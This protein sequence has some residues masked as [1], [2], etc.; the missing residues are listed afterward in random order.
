MLRWNSGRGS[1]AS[2]DGGADCRGQDE[3]LNQIEEEDLHK[4]LHS[5]PWLKGASGIPINVDGFAYEP[6]QKLLA[7]S[8][9]DGRVKVIGRI[10]CE[11]TLYSAAVKPFGTRQ[12]EFVVNRGALV[13]I[14]EA[15]FLEAW[16]IGGAVTEA[17][18]SCVHSMAQIKPE[19]DE[20]LCMA[21]MPREP[22]LLLGCKSGIMRAAAFV[23]AAGM[24]SC[25][26]HTASSLQLIPFRVTPDQM[27]AAGA[28]VLLA[29]HSFAG[30]HLVLAMHE[31]SGLV[32]WDM[33]SQKLRASLNAHA[34]NPLC[35]ELKDAGRV[36]ACCWLSSAAGG[37]GG[38]GTS[39]GGRDFA[40]GHEG[41]DVL[42]WSLPKLED[43]VA[44][45]KAGSRTLPPP[46]VVAT[47]RLASKGDIAEPVRG[48]N[49]VGQ[50]EGRDALL[51]LGGQSEGQPDGLM[52]LQLSGMAR[53]AVAAEQGAASE[54]ESDDDQFDPEAVTRVKMP[55]FGT[56]LGY[57]TVPR[58]GNVSGTEEPAAIVQLL[59]GGRLVVHS[60]DGSKP[61]VFTMPFQSLQGVSTTG[62]C[63]VP[64]THAPFRQIT[65]LTLSAMREVA[66]RCGAM[67]AALDLGVVAWSTGDERSETSQALSGGIP[68]QPNPDLSFGTVY[69][70]GHKDGHVRTWDVFGEQPQLLFSTPHLPLPVPPLDSPRQSPKPHNTST[71]V[72]ALDLAWQHGL[73]LTGH[74][75][76]EVRLYNFSQQPR[77]VHVALLDSVAPASVA[78]SPC[79]RLFPPNEPL[80]SNPYPPVEPSTT[81]RGAQGTN[82]PVMAH[83][84][85]PSPSHAQTRHAAQ[86]T[87]AVV[88]EGQ[89]GPGW[90][91]RLLC[92]LHQAEISCLTY[93]AATRV[94]VVGD[95]T[96]VV[97]V[98]DV[99]RALVLWSLPHL[100]LPV[101][102]ARLAHVRLPSQRERSMGLSAIEGSLPEGVAVPA[103]TIVS[104]D[105]CALVVSLESGHP[106]GKHGELR[107][108]SAAQV[109]LVELLDADFSPVWMR[110]VL[111]ANETIAL[112]EEA[113]ACRAAKRAERRHERHERHAGKAVQHKDRE[114]SSSGW[115][116]DDSGEEDGAPTQGLGHAAEAAESSGGGASGTDEDSDDVDDC[117]AAAIEKMEEA[118]RRGR[119][120]RVLTFGVGGDRRKTTTE[121]SLEDLAKKAAPKTDSAGEDDEDKEM[122]DAVQ[123]TEQPVAEHMLQVTDSYIRIYSVRHVILGSSCTSAS[124]EL[125][126]PVIFASLF[127]LDDAP[128]LLTVSQQDGCEEAEF[129]VYAV[130]SLAL[131]AQLP[132]RVALRGSTWKPPQDSALKIQR[133]L[134]ASRLGRTLLIGEDNELLQLS[135]M[136]DDIDPLVL[137]VQ[138]H[139][140]DLA[141]AAHAAA[142]AFE[143]AE[144]MMRCSKGSRKRR[145]QQELRHQ[146]EIAHAEHVKYLQDMQEVQRQREQQ[147]QRE[148]ADQAGV[149]RA[150]TSGRASQEA[151][152]QPRLGRASQQQQEE[153]EEGLQ[154]QGSEEI[155]AQLPT[156]SSAAVDSADAEQQ[157]QQEEEGGAAE[158]PTKSKTPRGFPGLLNK[159][160][161][162]ISK[163]FTTTTRT[164]VAIPTSVANVFQDSDVK[165]EVILPAASFTQVDPEPFELYDSQYPDLKSL[166][167]LPM[168]KDPRRGKGNR[169]DDGIKPVRPKPLVPSNAGSCVLDSQLP[170]GATSPLQAQSSLQ[171]AEQD[172]LRSSLDSRRGQRQGAGV[173]VS[174]SLSGGTP[175][176]KDA[177]SLR[178][179][180]GEVE[181]HATDKRAGRVRKS[182]SGLRASMPTF[183]FSSNI[184]SMG[185]R[186]SED[187]ERTSRAKGVS[188]DGHRG[189]TECNSPPGSR[190]NV[191]GSD[192]HTSKD[193]ERESASGGSGL[194]LLF[195]LSSRRREANSSSQQQGGGSCS[196]DRGEVAEGGAVGQDRR[197]DDKDSDKPL[198]KRLA[199]KLGLGVSTSPASDNGGAPS[200]T[201][202]GSDALSHASRRST[203]EPASTSVKDGGVLLA[204]RS[205]SP[206]RYEDVIGDRVSPADHPHYYHPQPS[207]RGRRQS[208]DAAPSLPSRQ[209]QLHAEEE[210]EAEE[211]RSRGSCAGV[212]GRDN[213]DVAIRRTASDVKRKYGRR[214]SSD[215][216]TGATKKS[217]TVGGVAS[218][219]RSKLAE[220]GEKLSAIKKLTLEM[221]G[222]AAGFAEMARQVA[223][224]EKG[225]KW[226][227]L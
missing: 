189:E 160:G 86:Q 151:Q 110:D 196:R 18:E 198:T 84:V 89:Q 85:A 71:A 218:Q 145:M 123:H 144:L 62:A 126:T 136:P 55:W 47:L 209:Q 25:D 87:A 140:W 184:S 73:L 224:Q 161:K 214:G 141:A 68:P 171:D 181:A 216:A 92:C 30:V 83:G 22:F 28:L 61:T 57:A 34:K 102:A 2:E 59:D 217:E 212:P 96:G 146:Q 98:I 219:T 131:L 139:D 107:P 207:M 152:L 210:E 82:S 172:S 41:G 128:A 80:F 74:I 225:K 76:G 206:P 9:T 155:G 159:V 40:T 188:T 199:M 103:V 121:L 48:L 93:C 39:G 78:A 6:I 88:G 213:A 182:S 114:A 162:G 211:M 150:S 200:P 223:E 129:Q 138:L 63:L 158:Q 46:T 179:S 111:V 81:P 116:G 127:Q 149:K 195:S 165:E 97:S 23:N 5:S 67:E 70:T 221:Q 105:A 11:V 17:G 117:L 190:Q 125:T 220:R 54:P 90:Q 205:R 1:T 108:K 26:V 169:E 56:P 109:L 154:G 118:K 133:I 176:A 192:P 113:A 32:L 94:A 38:T 29:S 65:S 100:Q 27:Q 45:E 31:Q 119:M 143:R 79:I 10:G 21:I 33:R 215:E 106:M 35:P 177:S 227:Q 75:N 180:A 201:S 156:S 167:S 166:M 174:V 72:T 130:P 99:S 16:S 44:A 115:C 142:V 191:A 101:I 24:L 20:V 12:L 51:V 187:G 95:K 120:Q 164:I 3:A 64:S 153:S 208:G 104:A 53:Q 19:G 185:R 137:P 194:G 66:H 175:T 50:P 4:V 193:K 197:D 15:G 226:Y 135:P 170:S 112:A 178:R 49:C 132:A 77:Q 36:S 13:R 60:M 37:T 122:E 8:T 202:P 52:L 14:C 148:E 186:T 134:S 42:I 163:G 157:Q 203:A 124:V 183:P 69:C 58:P 204:T 147:R 7:I 43:F 91:L 173:S 168:S 222:G